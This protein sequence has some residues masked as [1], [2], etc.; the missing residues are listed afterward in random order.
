MAIVAHG[1]SLFVEAKYASG[2]NVHTSKCGTCGWFM[3]CKKEYADIG[4]YGVLW[5]SLL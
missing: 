2:F 5:S 4:G 3:A 1:G